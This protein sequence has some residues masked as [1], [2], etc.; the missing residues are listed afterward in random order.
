[1]GQRDSVGAI[2][3]SIP[4]I[5][6]MSG[7]M[8]VQSVEV[9]RGYAPAPQDIEY[10]TPMAGTDARIDARIDDYLESVLAS[11]SPHRFSASLAE[12]ASSF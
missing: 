2:A 1:M 11:E 3:I 4:V 9:R 8:A 10:D 12:R 5:V 6:C 7:I